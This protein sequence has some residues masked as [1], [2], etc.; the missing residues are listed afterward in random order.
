MKVNLLFQQ[1]ESSD[2]LDVFQDFRVAEDFLDVTLAC[3]DEMLE[4]HKVVMSASSSFFRSLFRKTKQSNP[5]IYLHGIVYKDLVALL[6]Y[7]Y[8]GKAQILAEDVNRFMRVARELKIKGL[9]EDENKAGDAGKVA[10]VSGA[11]LLGQIKTEKDGNI[12]LKCGDTLSDK[13]LGDNLLDEGLMDLPPN[14]DDGEDLTDKSEELEIVLK[15]EG[16]V[17]KSTEDDRMMKNDFKMQS[18]VETQVTD[19]ESSPPP[20]WEGK[21]L[22]PPGRKNSKPSKVWTFGGFIKDENGQLIK[23]ETVCGLCG[24][25]QKYRNTPSHLLQHLQASHSSHWLSCPPT[26]LD[27]V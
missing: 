23:E 7:L 3:E 9:S 11:E 10:E 22:F 20:S 14:A 15:D 27:K 8:T 1:N 6:D 5:I 18:H 24:F 17:W 25:K 2:L 13:N 16:L 21:I 26:L 4:A 12:N 19:Q